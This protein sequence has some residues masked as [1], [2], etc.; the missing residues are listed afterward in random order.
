MSERIVKIAAFIHPMDAYLVKTRMDWEGVECFLFD[1]YVIAVNWFYSLVV[2]GVRLMVRESEFPLAIEILRREPE[3]PD[4]LDIIGESADWPQCP[5]CTSCKVG[6]ESLK[7]KWHC[8]ACGH[9][10]KED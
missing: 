7:R 10:W 2:G 1:E 6:Y 8:R 5:R 3:E 4:F 9:E